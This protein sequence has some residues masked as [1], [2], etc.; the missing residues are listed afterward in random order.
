MEIGTN[1]LVYTESNTTPGHGKFSGRLVVMP[2]IVPIV[3]VAAPRADDLAL[4]CGHLAYMC[5]LHTT[6]PIV[7]RGFL[8]EASATGLDIPSESS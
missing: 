3:V 2:E 7:Y 5:L 6:Q 1:T 4:V 8:T